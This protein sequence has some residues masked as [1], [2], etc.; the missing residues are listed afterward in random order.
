MALTGTMVTVGAGVGAAVAGALAG[1]VLYGGL[2]V[3]VDR[4]PASPR[5]VVLVVASL[6]GRIGVVAIV[7]V[8]LAAAGPVPLLCAVGGL[9]VVRAVLLRR[10]GPARVGPGWSIGGDRWT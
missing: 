7:L 10:L 1:L 8:G 4:L 6:V 3:T 9:L 5:P 2:A